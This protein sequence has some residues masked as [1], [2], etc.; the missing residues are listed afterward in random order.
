[1]K[2]M[3]FFSG[4]VTA[5]APKDSVSVEELKS[6]ALKALENYNDSVNDKSEFNTTTFIAALGIIVAVLTLFATYRSNDL[7]KKANK[8]AKKN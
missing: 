3:L 5:L 7:S 8:I 6:Q 1:M 4:L 2:I